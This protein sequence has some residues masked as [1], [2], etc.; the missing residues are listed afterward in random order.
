MPHVDAVSVVK[1]KG[2]DSKNEADSR[3]VE[4]FVFH[5][6]VGPDAMS[7]PDIE[8]SEANK[9]KS[10]DYLAQEAVFLVSYVS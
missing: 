7:P 3:D 10:G 4:N 1:V 2:G 5:A 9:A 6:E 8:G